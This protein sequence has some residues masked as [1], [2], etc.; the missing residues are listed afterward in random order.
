[1]QTEIKT[2]VDSFK[3]ESHIT[4]SPKPGISPEIELI[5]QRIVEDTLEKGNL[6][7]LT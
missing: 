1:V 4:P 6:A 2:A 7:G 3:S 5:T